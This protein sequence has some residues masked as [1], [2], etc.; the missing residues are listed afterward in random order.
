MRHLLATTGA[1]VVFFVSGTESVRCQDPESVPALKA[2]ATKAEEAYSRAEYHYTRV[3][4]SQDGKVSQPDSY[5][6]KLSGTFSTMTLSLG[7]PDGSAGVT[8]AY[9]YNSRYSFDLSRRNDAWV[10]TKIRSARHPSHGRYSEL[11]L[12]FAVPA[13]RLTYKAILDRSDTKAV[14]RPPADWRGRPHSEWVIDT[15]YHRI[16]SGEPMKRRYGLFFPA[17]HPGP[18]AGVRIYDPHD[19]SQWLTEEVVEYRPGD[20]P[21]PAVKSIETYVTDKTEG[22]R[23]WRISRI[24]VVEYRR[25]PSPPAEAEFTLSA[26]GLPEPKTLPDDAGDSSGPMGDVN[27][28]PY[29]PAANE[30]SARGLW[31]WAV[32]GVGA[33]VAGL[34]YVRYR[35]RRNGGD[36]R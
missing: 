36:D 7:S 13:G 9:G 34:A 5:T 6:V 24:E 20:E 23:P 22:Y 17:G 21:W 8:S 32:P 30:P 18:L 10:V 4:Y 15:I 27:Q 29:R 16:D 12:P 28:V 19:P 26:F 2:Y 3:S 31:W 14:R 33:I 35:R 1:V 11:Q 25:L